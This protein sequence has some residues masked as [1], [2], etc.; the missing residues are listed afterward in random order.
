[1]PV[2]PVPAGPGAAA[3]G[4]GAN[5]HGHDDDPMAPSSCP[6]SLETPA[7][8]ADLALPAGAVLSAPTVDRAAEPGERPD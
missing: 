4:G 1:V 2:V 8:L 3:T 5:L 7:D 6:S